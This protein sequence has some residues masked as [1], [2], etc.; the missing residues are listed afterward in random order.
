MKILAVET[1][2]SLGGI[3]ILSEDNLL[4]VNQIDSNITH[5]QKLMPLIQGVLEELN[6]QI[7]EFDAIAVSQGPGSFTGLRIG[8]S[9]A[10]ALSYTINKP[11]IA[12]STLDAMVSHVFTTDKQLICPLLDARR[13]EVYA[14]LY[15]KTKNNSSAE[16][17]TDFMVISI[18]DLCKLIKSTCIFVGNG[19]VKY[20]K[21]IKNILGESAIFSESSDNYP[22]ATEIARLAMRRLQNNDFDDSFTLKPYYIRKSDAQISITG[23]K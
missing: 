11:I 21:E 19:A 8:I 20:K 2:T 17:K 3:A 23:K 18:E 7:N 15:K 13:N 5:S 1:S 16:R 22:L 12:I 14:A 10:K 9:V 4:A 6:L